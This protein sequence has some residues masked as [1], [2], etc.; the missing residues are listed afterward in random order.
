V[1]CAESAAGKQEIL[2][3]WVRGQRNPSIVVVQL[4]SRVE[5]CSRARRWRHA[6]R[7]QN[8]RPR[9]LQHKN[10]Y[11]LHASERFARCLAVRQQRIVSGHSSWSTRGQRLRQVASVLTEDDALSDCE[12]LKSGLL[13]SQ[14]P[15]SPLVRMACEIPPLLKA[16]ATPVQ[17]SG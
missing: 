13:I 12:K 2:Q 16:H 4:L 8:S 17:S 3:T 11:P 14:F 10:L 15:N 9:L 7:F 6:S 5:P 1:R